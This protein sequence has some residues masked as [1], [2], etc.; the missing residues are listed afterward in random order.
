MKWYWWISAISL[1]SLMIPLKAQACEPIAVFTIL[2]GPAFFTLSLTVLLTV[3]LIKC[4]SFGLF[5]RRIPFAWG[6]LDMFLANVVSTFVGI[7]LAVPSPGLLL[8]LILLP[9]TASALFPTKRF[10]VLLLGIQEKK[11]FTLLFPVIGGMI[12]SLILF[13]VANQ[14]VNTGINSVYWILKLA[15]IAVA[16]I[17]S[18]GITT[19]YEEWIISRMHKPQVGKPHYFMTV[20]SANLMAFLLSGGIAA[21]YMLPK[22][23]ASPSFL[24]EILKHL[25]GV[26][27]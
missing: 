17:I 21:A 22:R 18:I 7:L 15:Y 2:A 20:F 13:T 24:V 25:V 23:L 9:V 6:F 12:L 11:A 19:I 14:I 16:F 8:F 4:I 26:D 27:V 1:L 10:A 3:V 5:E